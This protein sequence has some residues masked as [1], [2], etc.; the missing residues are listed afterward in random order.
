MSLMPSVTSAFSTSVKSLQLMHHAHDRF[1]VDLIPTEHVLYQLRNLLKIS[2]TSSND[3]A[4]LMVS[5]YA[6][7]HASAMLRR[8]CSS[9]A[10]HTA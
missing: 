10:G 8:I 6:C 2:S 1:E 3:M 9:D 4:M 5:W 7:R